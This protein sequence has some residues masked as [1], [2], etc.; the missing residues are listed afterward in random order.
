M[1][2]AI[3][4]MQLDPGTKP[5]VILTG[6][7]SPVESYTY[8]QTTGIVSLVFK[9]LETSLSSFKVSVTQFSV[10]TFAPGKTFEASIT[11]SA[12]PSG[13]VP[14]DTVSTT[15]TA[16]YDYSVSKAAETTPL[17]NGREVV[18]SFR[19]AGSGSNFYTSSQQIVDQRGLRS[20]QVTVLVRPRGPVL[21]S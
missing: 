9:D 1:T 11:G 6:S 20:E 4:E 17:T 12:T 8:D 15:V 3:A 7:D 21:R 18:Y 5:D 10:D 19:I 16:T 13:T 14:T 2:G